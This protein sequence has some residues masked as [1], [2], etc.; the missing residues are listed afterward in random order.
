MIQSTTDGKIIY[1]VDMCP[2]CSMDTAGS[3]QVGCP[4]QNLIEELE[5]RIQ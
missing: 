5:C 2:Y 4:N 1:T 3:H